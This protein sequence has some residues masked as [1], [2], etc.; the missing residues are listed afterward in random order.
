MVLPRAV[1]PP[2]SSQADDRTSAGQ[3]V[4]VIVHLIG[5]G[6][7]PLVPQ[8]E[9]VSKSTSSPH[10]SFG[11]GVSGPPH[12]CSSCHPRSLSG[13]CCS[14]RSSSGT[15]ICV[16]ATTAAVTASSTSTAAIRFQDRR[17]SFRTLSR[18]MSNRF[19]HWSHPLLPRS[20]TACRRQAISSSTVRSSAAAR[21][22]SSVTSG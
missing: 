19:R 5:N 22:S 15:M 21:G 13:R 10:C 20:A 9:G 1:T 14:V 8:R 4:P 3:P 7:S 2:V 6:V 16:H 12:R 17:R 11:S 18:E